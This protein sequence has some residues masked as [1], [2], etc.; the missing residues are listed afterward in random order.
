MLDSLEGLFEATKFYA[1][2]VAESMT[3]RARTKLSPDRGHERLVYGLISAAGAV[4]FN[5]GKLRG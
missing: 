5:L 3:D 2:I 4:T 1:S